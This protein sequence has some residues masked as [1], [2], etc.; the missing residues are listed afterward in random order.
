MGYHIGAFLCDTLY[1]RLAALPL[2]TK[3]TQLGPADENIV[4][5]HS[6]DFTGFYVGGFGLLGTPIA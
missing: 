1:G 3:I 5:I 6:E 2:W 4:E